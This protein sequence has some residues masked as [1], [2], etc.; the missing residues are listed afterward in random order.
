MTSPHAKVNLR[1]GDSSQPWDSEGS[2]TILKSTL[3]CSPTPDWR[4]EISTLYPEFTL[5]API[6]DG[7]LSRVFEIVER[8]TSEPYALK[9]IPFTP[10]VSSLRERIEREWKTLGMLSHPN[11][12]RG[13]GCRQSQANSYLLMELVAGMSLQQKVAR[14]GPLPPRLA[15]KYIGE[16][17]CGLGAAHAAGVIHRDVKPSNLLLDRLDAI[18]IV[19]FGMSLVNQLDGRSITIEHDDSLLGTVDYMAPEQA[20]SSHEVDRR[21]DIYSLGCT[22]YYLLIG[23]PPFPGGTIAARLMRHRSEPAPDIRQVLPHAP[24][25]LASMLDRMLTKDPADRYTCMEQVRDAAE[26]VILDFGPG[27]ELA[28]VPSFEAKCSEIARYVYGLATELKKTRA[29]QPASLGITEVLT[30]LRDQIEEV[31]HQRLDDSLHAPLVVGPPKSEAL[32]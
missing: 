19:D 18:K 17:A 31:L 4:G 11:I 22:L 6:A 28:S 27:P 2:T 5:I 12:I 32:S 29:D 9:A 13:Y 25:T 7:A 3:S 30:R 14:C 10:E 21:A 16:A 8:A 20:V 15:V 23:K 24:L 1:L 26:Q